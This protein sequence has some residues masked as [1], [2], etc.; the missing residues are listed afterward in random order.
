VVLNLCTFKSYVKFPGENDVDSTQF[1]GL[2]LDIE[3]L[4]TSIRSENYLH[5]NIQY[6][7]MD[8]K[9]RAIRYKNHGG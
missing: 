9:Q 4:A 2:M 3:F 6:W 1:V 5:Y 8:S 7:I